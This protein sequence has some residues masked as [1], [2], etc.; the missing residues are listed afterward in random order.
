MHMN[1]LC[2]ARYVPRTQQDASGRF[3]TSFHYIE[4]RRYE[5]DDAF[6]EALCSLLASFTAITTLDLALINSEL[7]APAAFSRALGTLYWPSLSRFALAH[8]P[9]YV[10][11][12]VAFLSRHEDS[13]RWAAL[14]DIDLRADR[15]PPPPPPP[16]RYGYSADSGPWAAFCAYGSALPGLRCAVSLAA[17]NTWRTPILPAEHVAIA[18]FEREML[19]RAQAHNMTEADLRENW[20]YRLAEVHCSHCDKVWQQYEIAASAG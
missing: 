17:P 8:A 20:T 2:E 1:L 5:N 13:L 14:Y 12:L 9:A 7:I 10:A 15:D 4:E 3:T 6:C 16:S 11:A 19:A 18:D